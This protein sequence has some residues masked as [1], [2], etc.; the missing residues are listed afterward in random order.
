MRPV[1]RS[2][3]PGGRGAREK[4]MGGAGPEPTTTR[5]V[6]LG[7]GSQNGFLEV[8]VELIT[9]GVG[10][11]EFGGRPAIDAAVGASAEAATVWSARGRTW[12]ANHSPKRGGCRANRPATRLRP[13]WRSAGGFG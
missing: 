5:V 3:V 4:D 8:G 9:A 11:V 6:R 13:A 2:R 10:V 7:P 1:E 12:S